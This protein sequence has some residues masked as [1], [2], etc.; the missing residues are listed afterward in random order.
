MEELL[1]KNRKLTICFFGEAKD[2][3]VF[4]VR[5]AKYFADEGHNVHLISY[6]EPGKQER[7]N[8]KMH[9]INKNF[10]RVRS[11]SLNILLNMPF[12]IRRTRMLIKEIKPDIIH[13]QC[14]TSYGTLASFLG[15]HPLIITAYGSDVLINPKK[16]LITKLITQ[17]ALGKADMIT[18]D[19]E[20][21]REEMVRLGINRNKI[22][23]INF[24]VDTQKFFPQKKSA[25]IEKI[26]GTE[27][28]G[29][30]MSLRG[31]E[32]IYSIRT[33]IRAVPGIIR[34]APKTK[35]IIVGG[36]SME[37]YLKKIVN[38]L[39]IGDK[40]NFV[41]WIPNNNIT[42]YLN[43]ADVYVSTS[44]SDAGIASST[45]EAMSCGLPVIVTD[46]ADN[47]EWVKDGN[48]GFLF[49]AG[50]SQDLSKKVLYLLQNE[51]IR[52]EFG[53]R[54]RKI[55]EERNSYHGE[56]KKVEEFYFRMSNGRDNYRICKKCIMDTSDPE[57]LF[58][59]DGV[60]SHCHHYEKV[61]KSMP[62]KDALIPLIETIKKSGIG[63]KYDCIIGLSGG[64]DSSTIALLA[65]EH[66][67][68]PLAIHVDNGWNSEL[69]VANIEKIVKKLNIDFRT[70][71]IDWEEFKD[72]QIAF[73]MASEPNIEIPTD[74]AIV[75][76]LYKTAIEFDVKYILHGGN[77]KTEAIMP[78]SWGYDA[79]DLKHLKAI[80]RLFGK[81]KLKTFPTLS[82]WH[83]FYCTLIKKIR[84]MGI[85]NYID[86]NKDKSK[87]ILL[88]ELGWKEYGKKHEESI[89]TRFFQNY[90]LPEKFGIDKR[91][92]H[93]STLINSGQMTREHA[94][95]EMK[96]PLYE[97][98]NAKRDEKEYVIK[99]LGL[100]NEEFENIM[101]LPPKSY[102]SYPNDDLFIKR[103]VFLYVFVKKLLIK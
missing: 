38:E 81:K 83:I 57:I 102:K 52:R 58:D 99:K 74:H 43:V 85:L 49:Q 35:F 96:K 41:G 6:S 23:I 22:K 17:Y 1:T 44:L 61:E 4:A 2:E 18:C 98:E 24:G 46:V 75:A 20:H 62:S 63:K 3:S 40:V 34:E 73:L 10:P 21:M 55:I 84:Y 5:W 16:S 47:K 13:A 89:F 87:A 70:Y 64:V 28:C 33:L 51:Q 94:M 101:M 68:R 30:V 14:I 26:L 54:S 72:I 97:Y 66:G 67:L 65:K 39:K 8:V 82:I 50:D 88:D 19:A 92:A 42:E 79:K 29:V 56:M 36:G 90:I 95:E 78:F 60:C 77:L 59:D 80:H 11:R 31:L 86:Y 25:E 12:I 48:N 7:G 15:F 45:A 37:P 27:D 69:S 71:V 32:P 76:A 103:L 100:T 9:I 93:F 53:S 91:R